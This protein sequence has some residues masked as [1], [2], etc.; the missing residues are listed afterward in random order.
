[1]HYIDNLVP[2]DLHVRL[3]VDSYEVRIQSNKSINSTLNKNLIHDSEM[4]SYIIQEIHWIAP[5][6]DH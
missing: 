4:T 2:L 3:M 1:M 6:V 5:A